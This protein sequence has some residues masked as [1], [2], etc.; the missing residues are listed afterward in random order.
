M[1]LSKGVLVSVIGSHEFCLEFC[2]ITLSRLRIRVLVATGQPNMLEQLQES[3]VLLDD[4][5]KGLSTYLENRL[6]L[7][8]QWH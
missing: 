8:R 4:I 2:V 1:T 3:N 7:P 5:Q 6:H